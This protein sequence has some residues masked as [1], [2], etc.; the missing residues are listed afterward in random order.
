MAAAVR[1]PSKFLRASVGRRVDLNCEAT[2]Q[3]VQQNLPFQDTVLNVCC[4]TGILTFCHRFLM[5][6]DQDPWMVQESARQTTKLFSVSKR[7]HRYG[8]INGAGFS[9]P[10]ARRTECARSHFEPGDFL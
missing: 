10:T 6:S 8:E 7:Y 1:G 4:D 9:S 5:G 2:V 3:M